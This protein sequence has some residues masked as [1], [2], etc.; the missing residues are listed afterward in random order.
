MSRLQV[1]GSLNM[2]KQRVILLSTLAHT[3]HLIAG[4]DIPDSQY[5]SSTLVGFRQHVT[6]RHAWFSPG[7]RF[8]A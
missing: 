8:L 1:I 4:G 6:D 7:S 3:S 5:K 2:T